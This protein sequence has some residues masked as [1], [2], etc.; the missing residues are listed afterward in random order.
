MKELKMESWNK[1][2]FTI[3][4]GQGVS[5]FTSAVIQMSIVWYLTA[6]TG[7]AAVLAVTTM[8]GFV[9]QVVLGPFIGVLIDRFNRKRVMIISDLFIAAVSMIIV[10]WG[11]F[12]T[13]P[14]P[15]IMA[16][17]FARALGTTCHTPSLQAVTPM[18]V[19]P[20]Q[21]TRYAGYSQGVES[22]S[23]LVSPAIAAI[24]YGFLSLDNIILFDVTG[25]VFAVFTLSLVKIPERKG[26]QREDLPNIF[27]GVKEGI[28]VI[29]RQTGLTGLLVICALYAVIYFPIGTMFPLISMEY[30]RGGVVGSSIVE[31]VFAVGMLIGSL[32]LGGLGNRLKKMSAIT[33]SIFLYG[34]GLTLTGLLPP[35]GFWIFVGLSVLMGISIPFYRGVQLAIFQIKIEDEYLGRVLALVTSIRNISMPVGLMMAAGFTEIIGVQTFFLI[36][37]VLCLVLGVVSRLMPSV[38]VLN[39]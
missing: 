6:R 8:L 18:V 37:G 13:V 4:L 1:K 31:T 2:F 25:A 39:E 16:V 15:V 7:S 14:I 30:F 29:R 22:V 23:T 3:W 19:P 21:L 17:V 32:I 28:Q 33:F 12:Q 24:L 11:K 5:I 36:S 10:I 34:T 26:Q 38:R 35:E 27:G 9:P 20:E